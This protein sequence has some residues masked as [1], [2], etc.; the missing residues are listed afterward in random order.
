M[1]RP[2]VLVVD[3][4]PGLRGWAMLTLREL[5]VRV[6]GAANGQEALQAIHERPPDLVLLDLAMP[7]L[8]GAA[9]IERLRRIRPGVP[10]IVMSRPDRALAA[11]EAYGL[12]GYLGK[13][14]TAQ[15]L[16]AAVRAQLEGAGGG[17]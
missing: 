6:A 16:V 3:D 13:P 1:H 5:G 10:I 2:R 8:D 11:Y 7:V 12:A 14:F 15:R 17:R 9:V 4:D